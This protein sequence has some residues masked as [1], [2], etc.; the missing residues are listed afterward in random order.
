MTKT[1]RDLRRPSVSRPVRYVMLGAGLL[2]ALGGCDDTRKILGID[3]TAPDEFRIVSRP[4]LTLPPDYALRPPQPGAARPV[5]DNPTDTARSA[6]VQVGGGQPGQ[7]A[8]GEATPG[9]SVMLQRVAGGGRVDPAIR[10]TLD[11]ETSQL[12][13]ADTYLLERLMFW[14][15]PEEPG[16]VVDAQREAQRLRENA[17]LGRPVTSGDTPTIQ[18]RQRGLLEGIF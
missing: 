1:A 14:R 5:A 12:A 18:R 17:A 13:D 15:K 2:L 3:K 6:L 9:E 11:R 4:P 10:Q 8:P 7:F 16:T